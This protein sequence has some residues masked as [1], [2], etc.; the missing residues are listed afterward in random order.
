MM[1]FCM[2]DWSLDKVV[3][4]LGLLF[5]QLTFADTSVWKVS[6]DNRHLYLGGTVHI[7]S[8]T[9][10]PLPAPFDKA[11]HLSH[12]I[13]LETDMQKLQSP[14]FQ[15][16]MLSQLSYGGGRTLKDVLS[17]ETYGKLVRYCESRG[18]PV[19]GVHGFKPGLLTSVL[20]LFELQ[21]LGL[22]GEGVD[23][24]FN[25][26]A[27]EDSKQLGQLETVEEQLNFLATMG[28]GQEDETIE[29][30]LKDIE[31][32]PKL[33]KDIKQ[34]WRVGD[35]KKLEK[36]AIEPYLQE[37]PET[38]EVLL[39]LRNRNW[40]PKIEAMLENPEVEFIL[41]GV[42]HLA[43]DQGLLAQLQQRGYTLEQQ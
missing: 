22:A 34:N 25:L 19:T 3:I 43:G 12:R 40:M 15:G 20:L 21:R 1:Y 11:Y 38:F 39:N 5:S 26:K 14:E 18:I 16:V 6:K 2:K 29:Y 27:I 17:N 33:M 28:E 4:C 8:N 36:V 32:L 37:F 30:T 10:Y 24:F 7:L 9:D 23:A 41:V 42:L 13:V 35:M 31:N